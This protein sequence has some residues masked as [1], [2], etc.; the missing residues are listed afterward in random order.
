[1]TVTSRRERPSYAKRA[2]D[3]EPG[4]FVLNTMTRQRGMVVEIAGDLATVNYLDGSHDQLPRPAFRRLRAGGHA[5][6]ARAK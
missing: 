4:D 5:F 1:M 6:D 2:N 3:L